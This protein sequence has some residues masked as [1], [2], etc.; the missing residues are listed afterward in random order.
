MT[1]K[2]YQCVHVLNTGELARHI[3]PITVSVYITTCPELRWTHTQ[4]GG[5]EG[6]IKDGQGL[7]GNILT[8]VTVTT[9]NSIIYYYT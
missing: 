4:E 6:M 7:E 9:S 5:G 1:H 2:A 8:L 3:K